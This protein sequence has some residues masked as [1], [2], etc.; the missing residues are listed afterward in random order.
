VIYVPEPGE[1]LAVESIVRCPTFR[2]LVSVPVAVGR[3][4]CCDLL[5]WY[6]CVLLCP[7]TT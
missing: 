2:N 4:T 7:D 1:C 5:V 6:G 3:W